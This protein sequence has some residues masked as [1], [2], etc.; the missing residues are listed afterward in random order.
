MKKLWR[1]SKLG[2]KHELYREH[3]GKL[4]PTWQKN[5][6]FWPIFSFFSSFF[7]EIFS[8]GQQLTLSIFRS[9][10]QSVR[11]KISRKLI[12]HRKML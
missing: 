11:Q 2:P 10:R 7:Y 3:M 1:Y 5:Q 8:C 6:H 12:T 4:W 9:D